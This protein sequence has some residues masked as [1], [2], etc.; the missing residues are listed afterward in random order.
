MK[1]V[2]SSLARGLV[3]PIPTLPEEVTN[4]AGLP[5]ATTF[6]GL[7]VELAS[8]ATS[9]IFCV[10]VPPVEFAD[11]PIV[12]ALVFPVRLQFQTWAFTPLDRVFP[13]VA[14]PIKLRA[15]APVAPTAP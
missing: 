2:T 15:D 13:P 11:S 4:K 1:P 14:E 5:W 6:N 9:K 7:A 10:P 8:V 12:M 3:V